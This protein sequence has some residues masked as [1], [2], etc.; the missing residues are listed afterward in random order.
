MTE[1]RTVL[2]TGCS[3]GGLGAALCLALHEQGLRVFA[4]VRNPSKAMRLR[5][6][7]LEILPLDVTSVAS[8]QACADEVG[9]RTGGSLDI[10]VNNAGR[11]YTMPLMDVKLD[12]FRRLFD[13]NFFSVFMTTQGFFPLLR[14]STSRPLLVINT[15]VC[16]GLPVPFSGAYNAS[17]AAA[18]MLAQNLRLELAAFDIRVVEL[19]TGAVD[20]NISK[21]AESDPN[22]HLP[23]D[24]VYS[25]GRQRIE[26]AIL[27]AGIV[28]DNMPNDV[29]AASVTRLL[30]RRS[31]PLRIWKGGKITVSWLASMAPVGW[32][33]GPLK[34]SIGL[35]EV[36][37][38][39]RKERE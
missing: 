25:P 2:V 16:A 26:A 6:R 1:K 11:D 10:L 28:E 15:S 35:D 38:A 20:S 39:I 19:R 4:T 33:D 5:E 37:A 17:K 29:W 23:A 8:I 21:I 7:G 31:P 32:L 18:S 13:T 12:E 22:R 3:D 36:E 24:S 14:A 9:R 27:G 34:Q 30:L